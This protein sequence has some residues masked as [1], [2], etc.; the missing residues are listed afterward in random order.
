MSIRTYVHTHVCSSSLLSF[1]VSYT[2]TFSHTSSYCFA[3]C[4]PYF[5][6]RGIGDQEAMMSRGVSRIA[7]RAQD[8]WSPAIFSPF[9]SFPPWPVLVS[10]SRP[11]LT[12]TTTTARSVLLHPRANVN[13]VSP[14]TRLSSFFFSPPLTL[15]HPSRERTR[16]TRL[17][18]RTRVFKESAIRVEND[19]PRA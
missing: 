13:C 19:R 9:L 16:E 7:R 17:R 15:L 5:C 3:V 8:F 2:M 6:S 4:S 11:C 1:L 14:A 10:S 18:R 12:S